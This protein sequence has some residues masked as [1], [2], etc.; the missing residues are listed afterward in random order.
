MQL[1]WL[2]RGLR[3]GVLT[4][5]YPHGT[6]AMPD[7]WRGVVEL[8]PARCRPESA[9]PPCVAACPSSALWLEWTAEPDDAAGVRFDPLACVACGRCVTACPAD[10]L[11]MTPRFELAL[12]DH[13][14]RRA[15]G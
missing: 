1:S 13:P 4:T 3:T 7:G 2:V 5:R 9:K 8:D 15:A 14:D 10:A 6:D 11:R 12:P